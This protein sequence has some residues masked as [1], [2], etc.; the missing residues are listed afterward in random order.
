M[1]AK[2]INPL[3]Q[4]VEDLSDQYVELV[5]ELVE[6]F[7]PIRP[8]WSAD[9]NAN[10]QFWRYMGTDVEKGLRATILPWLMEAAALMGAAPG[11]PVA[12]AGMVEEI[13]TSPAATD[14]IHPE[15]VAQIPVEILE[16]VQAS[17]PKDAEKHLVKM[18]KMAVERGQLGALFTPTAPAEEPQAMSTMEPSAP[19]PVELPGYTASWPEYGGNP[20]LRQK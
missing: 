20:F 4:M 15:L 13:F 17:G 3:E 19:L 9:L 8:W 6:E 5:Y 7:A 11:D 2:E 18:E 1:A 16:L 12:A 14:I 10:Q